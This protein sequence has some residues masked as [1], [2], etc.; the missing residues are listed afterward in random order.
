MR[1]QAALMPLS[2]LEDAIK[3]IFRSRYKLQGRPRGLDETTRHPR[4]TRDLLRIAR[5]PGQRREYAVVTGS[6]GK[7]STTAITAR[8]LQHL[9]HRVGMLTSPHLVHWTE[10]IRMDGRAIPEADFLRILDALAPH[11]DRIEAGLTDE[12]YLSPQG[13]FLAIALRWFD[14]NGVNVGVLEVGR[15]GRYDDVAVVDNRVSLFTPILVE[16]A[17]YLGATVARIAWH[18]AGIIK[19]HSWAYSLPQSRE[20][21]D[22]IKAE[23]DQRQAEFYWLS[24]LDM[25]EH[26]RDVPEGQIMRLQRY[27]ETLLSLHGRYEIANATLAVQAAGKLHEFLGGVEHR[28]PDYVARIKAGLADVR[29]PGRVQRLQA[30]PAVWV[31]GAINTLS[32]QAFL[33]SVRA[34]LTRPVAIVAGVPDDRD[35]PAVY[36]VLAQEADALILTQTDIHPNIHFPAAED[37]LRAARAV[38]DEVTHTQNLEE[39]LKVAYASVGQ[40][41]TVLLAVAQPL[42]GEAMLLWQ[43]ATRDI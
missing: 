13:I 19:A 28:S 33:D 10:R 24:T 25:G 27:G 41:G 8:L 31:D 22:V 38:H 4:A 36:G 11:I 39:A 43:V 29:W 9:G 18:K 12:Q 20:V 34:H 42:V 15:G 7:G 3:L 17:Q 40:T 35:Y 21:L 2:T 30:Q 14:E 23:A 5:L 32:A 26:V 1:R 37:A 16:H 6:K